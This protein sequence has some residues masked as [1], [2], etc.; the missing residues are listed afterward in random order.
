MRVQWVCCVVCTVYPQKI[1]KK[2]Q[3]G[4]FW[5]SIKSQEEIKSRLGTEGKVS[6]IK[7]SGIRRRHVAIKYGNGILSR[8]VDQVSNENLWKLIVHETE[9]KELNKKFTCS[10][11]RKKFIGKWIIMWSLVE[12]T[13]ILSRNP[14][15]VKINLLEELPCE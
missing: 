1:V 4:I 11:E 13:K 14:W 9:V 8:F 5:K 15:T 3:W 6:D 2:P 12:L 7:R 10:K